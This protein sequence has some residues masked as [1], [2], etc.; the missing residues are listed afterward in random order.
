MKTKGFWLHTEEEYQD[1]LRGL[2]VLRAASE[3][4]KEREGKSLVR[5]LDGVDRRLNGDR[6]SAQS[7][8]TPHEE[9]KRT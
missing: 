7:C 2:K 4:R 6:R 5:R 9:R 8:T 1:I 3:E